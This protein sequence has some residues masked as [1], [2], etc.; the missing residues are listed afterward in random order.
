MTV[1]VTGGTGLTGS[2][3]ARLLAARGERVVRVV[4][5]S[6]AS[7]DATLGIVRADVRDTDTF[8]RALEGA[9]VLVHV[10]GVVHGV[11]VASALLRTPVE[12]VI[13]VSTASVASRHRSSRNVY[14]AG[15]RALEAS[16]RNLCIVRPTMIYGSPRDRNVHRVVTAAS[17][18]GVL[19]LVTAAGRLQPIHYEDL[20]EAIARLVTSNVDGVI[21]AGGPEALTLRRAGEIVFE[22]LGRRPR[23]VTVAFGPAVAFARVVDRFSRSRFA[24]RLERAREDRTV[25]N[26]RLTGVTGLVQRPFQTG[27]G[28]EVAEMRALG[29]IR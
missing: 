27:V 6:V 8:A 18:F 25:D 3:I 29:R 11:A 14:L 26:T 22:A 5:G 2:A 21:A 24:E 7:R 12:R 23:F 13:V 28:E 19:P 20:A 1:V 9:R 15:E 16:S 10:A 17:R 4:R